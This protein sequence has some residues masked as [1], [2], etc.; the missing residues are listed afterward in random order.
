MSTVLDETAPGRRPPCRGATGAAVPGRGY[1]SSAPFRPFG[2]VLSL[3][4]KRRLRANTFSILRRFR[5]GA[6]GNAAPT[7]PFDAAGRGGT[8]LPRSG[9]QGVMGEG[10]GAK[11]KQ[12]RWRFILT[13]RPGPCYKNSL[14]VPRR[15]C[16]ALSGR[17]AP[18]DS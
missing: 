9:G 14:E 11:R 3:S 7:R 17:A 8:L 13:L 12:D 1:E 5:A 15:P 4:R 2:N 6:A 16:Y 10:A 18:G